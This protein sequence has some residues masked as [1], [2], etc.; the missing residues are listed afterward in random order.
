MPRTIRAG[1]R[2]AQGG[3]DYG[4]LLRTAGGQ[5]EVVDL[6][7]RGIKGNSH[8]VMMDKNSDVVSRAHST[9]G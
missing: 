9:S 2:F 4:G 7:D 6:P 3:V 1:R 5:I 8:M